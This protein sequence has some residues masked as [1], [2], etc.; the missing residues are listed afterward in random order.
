MI[1]LGLGWKWGIPI[2]ILLC[3]SFAVWPLGSGRFS[4]VSEGDATP[5]YPS[6]ASFFSCSGSD[7][8]GANRHVIVAETR[9]RSIRLV[10]AT[11]VPILTA[12]GNRC[13][14]AMQRDVGPL[15]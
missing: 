2:N 15:A 10:D 8:P 3:L 11:F 4:A 7:D 5:M 9:N 1:Q 13:A 14:A 12:S 6:D